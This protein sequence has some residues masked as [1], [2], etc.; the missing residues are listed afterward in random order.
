M[1]G[2]KRVREKEFV[3]T[4]V[5]RFRETLSARVRAH[6]QAGNEPRRV[7]GEPGELGMRAVYATVPEPTPWNELVG[8]FTRV[9]GAMARLGG[10]TRQAVASKA[11]RRRLLRV[12]T[13]DGVYLFPVWQFAPSGGMLSG[14]AEVLSL[15]RNVDVDGTLAG[16]FRSEDPDLGDSPCNA[17]ER[18]EVERVIA[19]ARTA[20]L[21]LAA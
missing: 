7:L 13:S 8:P 6:M 11:A 19:A 9:E 20:R 4:A 15:F 21:R 3:E 5:R 16:W 18:G 2:S 14:M 12:V 17:L 1:S 10:I